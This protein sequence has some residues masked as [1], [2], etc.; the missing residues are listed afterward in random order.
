MVCKLHI[1]KTRIELNWDISTLKYYV[2][3][4][5]K[6]SKTPRMGI[7]PPGYIHILTC[8]GD[9]GPDQV[10]TRNSIHTF[11]AKNDNDMGWVLFFPIHCMKHSYHLATQSSLKMCD[12]SLRNLKRGFKYFTSL[13]T[14]SHTWRSH[15]AKIR[16]VWWK[17]H[18]GEAGIGNLKATFR[19]P[20]LA[21]AGRWG[22]IDGTL[23]CVLAWWW[24]SVV[25]SVEWKLDGFWR[26]AKLM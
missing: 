25:Y 4:K 22:S 5:L 18:E 15:L 21:I 19:M 9:N 12:V 23:V 24:Y 17:Q 8:T 10:G 13:A 11:L 2:V 20:P 14:L 1:P 7:I 6:R 16:S 3:L 26:F